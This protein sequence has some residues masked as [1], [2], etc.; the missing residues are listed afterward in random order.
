MAT[1]EQILRDS[2]L[3]RVLTGGQGLRDQ[4]GASRASVF[5][6]SRSDAAQP[7]WLPYH[8]LPG[9]EAFYTPAQMTGDSSQDARIDPEAL[10]RY[11][12]ENGYQIGHAEG[13][14]QNWRWLQDREGKAVLEPQNYYTN[15]RTAALL[16]M[17]GILG[18]AAAHAASTGAFGSLGAAPTAPAA[19]AA[20]GS[21]A[22][23]P[24]GALSG[25][26]PAAG[27][28]WADAALAGMTAP[29]MAPGFAAWGA[30][31]TAE[32]AA[33]LGG[34]TSLGGAAGATGSV[35]DMVKNA[36]SGTGF[37]AGWL[38]NILGLVGAGVNQMNLEKMAKDNRDWQDKRESDRRRRQ[39]PGALPAMK[40]TVYRKSDQG[41]A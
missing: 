10:A 21:A 25:A 4:L 29:E 27:G 2:S 31:A 9:A 5:G 17:A 26:A 1:L 33:G 24:A 38:T 35:V 12:D 20:G 14:N 32:T 30:P 3:N 22:T 15:D 7:T 11:L 41:A 18:P 40:T 36:V 37:D 19:P 23:A 34:L 13:K 6:Q 8:E 16:G 39:M 28:S